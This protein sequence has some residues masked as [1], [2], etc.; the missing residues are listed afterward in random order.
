[1]QHTMMLFNRVRVYD[2][3]RLVTCRRRFCS[4]SKQVKDQCTL[5]AAVALWTCSCVALCICNLFKV[6]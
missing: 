4:T 1:M 3:N 5:E 6:R 2:I